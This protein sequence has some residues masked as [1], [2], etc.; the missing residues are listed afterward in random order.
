MKTDYRYEQ[1]SSDQYSAPA[2]TLHWIL[3]VLFIGMVGL[4]WYMMDIEDSPGSDWYF[5][6]HKSIG[7][8]VI[9]LV[10][11]R[12]AWRFTH[13]PAALPS[14]IP[15][16]QI[17]AS[18]ISHQALYVLMFALPLIGIAGAAFSKSGLVFFGS[19]LPRVVTANHDVAE[20]FFSIHSFAAWI[21]VILV[22]LHVLAG[23]KHLLIDKDGVFQ[24]M[25]F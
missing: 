9:F 6:L 5:N 25:W 3:A 14:T 16:W 1:A 4:G 7:L 17:I 19:P 2:K 8:V 12:A 15:S 21:L 23:L 24:R 10:I 13:R 11:L 20:F 18:A 22:C